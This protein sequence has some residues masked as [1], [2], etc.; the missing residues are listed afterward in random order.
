MTSGQADLSQK[1]ANVQVSE[2]A[3]TREDQPPQAPGRGGGGRGRG[4]RGRGG[5]GRGRGGRNTTS[6]SSSPA[7]EADTSLSK[8]LSYLLRHGAQAESLPISPSGWV[9][10][11]AVLGRP[12]VG[13][14]RFPASAAAAEGEGEEGKERVGAEV[15]DVRR[16]VRESSKKRFQLGWGVLGEGK[17]D[18]VREL[19][20][21][22][23]GER[24]REGKVLFIR[25]VQGHSIKEVSSELLLP[26]TPSNLSLLH[27]SHPLPRPS[28]S[29]TTTDPTPPPA[30]DDGSK[31][32]D[33]S[34][35]TVVH[36]TT[37]PAWERILA[38][39]GLNRMGR[40]HIHLA[41]G[42]PASF[43]QP[44]SSQ[45]QA[46]PETESTP[47][48]TPAIISGLRP[49]SSVILWIDVPRALEEGHPPFYL[50][51]NGVVLTPGCALPSSSSGT[52]PSPAD[53]EGKQSSQQQKRRGRGQAE[54]AAD[55]WLSLRYV[56]RVEGRRRKGESTGPEGGDGAG[57]SA[58]P[59]TQEWETIWE[60]SRDWKESA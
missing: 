14:L 43:L 31:N 46:E 26:I 56:T 29:S 59:G 54:I 50:S 34:T 35:L 58:A 10:V 8:T 51:E 17:G 40:N 11:L 60:R 24:E 7:A 9:S 55:G 25:A 3:A 32:F 45:P 16:V 33:P 48:P 4:G 30:T 12:K 5:R 42:L 1:M 23:D 49:T 18:E 27:P 41:R 36:G 15:Q 21:E 38:S 47:T 6:D 2:A 13:K 52:E 53:A 44:S 22:D 19:E 20:V 28:S 57:S 39:G 37:Y